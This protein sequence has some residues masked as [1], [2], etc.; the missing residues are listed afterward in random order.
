MIEHHEVEKVCE[1]PDSG[2]HLHSQ[3]SQHRPCVLCHFNFSEYLESD[4]LTGNRA[5]LLPSVQ[6][7]SS[8]L[9]PAPDRL[10]KAIQQRGPPLQA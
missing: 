5:L 9:L 2:Q 3:H 6:L 7:P 8:Y 10:G 1:A 4:P